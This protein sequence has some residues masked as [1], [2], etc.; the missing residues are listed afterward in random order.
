M[1]SRNSLALFILIPLLFIR[2]GWN[3]HRF[4]NEHAVDHLPAAMF[5]FEDHRSYLSEHSVDPDSDG[6]P[7]YYHYIDID[8][9]PEFFTGQLPHEWQAMIDRYGQYTVENN[10]VVPWVIEWWLEDLTSAMQNGNWTNAWQLAAE[11]GHY[12]ADSHQALHLT[13]NY[14][15]YDTGNDGIHSRYE[16]K[17]MDVYRSGI[18]MDDSIATFWD[19][20]L[21]SIF[22]YIDDIYPL[23]DLVMAADDRAS[24][25]DRYYGSTYYSMMWEDLGEVTTWSVQRAIVDVA[26]LWYTAWENAGRP[27]PDGVVG[28][29]EFSK[30]ESFQ[31]FAYPNPFNGQTTLTFQLAEAGEVSVDILDLTGRLISTLSTGY[32]G[33]GDYRL[34]WDG[35]DLKHNAVSSGVYLGQLKT[36]EQS[37]IQ[38]L[39]LIK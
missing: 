35:F 27:Y 20:P 5:F 36:H 30:P 6:D 7:G 29:N 11:M 39:I 15:G 21:D 28:V 12:I 2:W 8:H 26:A 10:G 38:K 23:V 9:Y 33:A 19:T 25:V 14:N 17:M 3:S 34:T 32:R 1:S 37:S 13:V 4:I 18:S 22:S 16:T 31:L 24:A